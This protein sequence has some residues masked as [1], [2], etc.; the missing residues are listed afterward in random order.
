VKNAVVPSI[1]GCVKVN[2]NGYVCDQCNKGYFLI[3]GRCC[4]KSKGN[5]HPELC[6]QFDD[7]GNFC[8]T[9]FDKFFLEDGECCINKHCEELDP[10]TFECVKCKKGYELE[11]GVCFEY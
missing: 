10:D 2:S 3:H 6:K 9:C 8:V 5:F 4:D 1:S 11:F 7:E